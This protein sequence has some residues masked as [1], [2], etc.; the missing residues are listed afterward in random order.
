MSQGARELLDAFAALGPRLSFGLPA[1]TGARRLL[2]RPPSSRSSRIEGFAWSKV[3][4]SAVATVWTLATENSQ[5]ENSRVYIASISGTAPCSAAVQAAQIL[6]LP[7]LGTIVTSI[8]TYWRWQ[9]RMEKTLG[10]A[11]QYFRFTH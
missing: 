6:N 11:R 1:R 5:F 8:G 10:P 3:V 2:R 9:A 4:L 7:G